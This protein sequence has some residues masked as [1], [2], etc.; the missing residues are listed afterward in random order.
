MLSINRNNSCISPLS[1]NNDRVLVRDINTQGHPVD[2]H[3]NGFK[4]LETI[5]AL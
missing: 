5:T 3:D 1:G 2:V 4:G